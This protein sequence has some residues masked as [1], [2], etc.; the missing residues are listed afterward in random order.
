MKMTSDG[1]AE[2]SVNTNDEP[3]PNNPENVV[4]IHSRA[5]WPCA[6]FFDEKDIL[7][8]PTANILSLI[9]I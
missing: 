7:A 4:K 9:H 3:R 5:V 2:M 1:V 6:I 8:V